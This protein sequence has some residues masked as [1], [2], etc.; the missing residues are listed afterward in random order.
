MA[1][2]SPALMRPA[3]PTHRTIVLLSLAAFASAASIRVTDALLVRIS[4]DYG[5]SLASAANVVTVFAI[6]Y[7][8]MQLAMGPLGDRHGKLRVIAAACAAAAV[9]SLACA[10]APTFETLVI[11]RA[12]A[13]AACACVIP[14]SMAWIGDVTPYE[15]RQGVLARFL[16]GQIMGLSAGVALGGFA[17]DGATWQWPFAVLAAWF[18]VIGAL[19]GRA[20]WRQPAGAQAP[21]GNAVANL[22]EVLRTP[23]VA[24]ILA[25]VFLE[26]LVLLGPLA[27]VATHLHLVRGAPMSLAGTMFFAV[28]AGGFI[29]AF[30]A[31][32]I[33][34]VLGEARLAILGTVIVS[35]SVAGIAL[36]PTLAAA[37]FSCFGAGMG[38]YMLHNTLQ[39]NATQMAPTR[40]GTA[41][42]LFAGIFFLGQSGGVAVAGQLAQAIG[43]AWT[44]T[45]SALAVLPVGIG[46]A[47]S[48]RAAATRH[49]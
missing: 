9:A 1:P 44:L 34:P 19:I 28:S 45:A 17:A 10:A 47:L 33:V 32:R 49:P 30:F 8:L 5:V 41:V 14:L 25:T 11:A 27:F 42:A 35:A 39:T 22:L 12:A 24:R 2:A 37:P 38:F 13:G 43:T 26:G 48:R 23:G 36:A 21:G 4:G 29:F 16:L 3:L 7:G 15:S 40:R 46:F 31:K 18:V 6:L 20:G